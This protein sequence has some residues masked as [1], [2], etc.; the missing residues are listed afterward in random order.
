MKM[1]YLARG[2]KL[3]DH[4]QAASV[5][6]RNTQKFDKAMMHLPARIDTGRGAR[7]LHC[8]IDDLWES[9]A[10]ITLAIDAKLPREFVLVLS[11]EGDACRQC[12]T[13]WRDRLEISVE[14]LPDPH[15]D[16]NSGRNMPR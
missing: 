6:R 10:R 11:A 7:L 1:S 8:V 2:R 4:F 12:R 9:G 14:F 15:K 16:R 3:D 5:A 13:L